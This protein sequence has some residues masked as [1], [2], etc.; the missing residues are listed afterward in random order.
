MIK[1][2]GTVGSEHGFTVV[3]LL[4]TLL[5]IT[6]VFGSFVIT[7]TTIQSINKKSLDISAANVT[8]FAKLQDYENINF[9]DLPSTVTGDLEEVEDFSDDLPQSLRSPRVGKVYINGMS[10]SLKHIVVDISFGAGA[11]QRTI[12]Y[13]SFINRNGLGR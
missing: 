10:D 2:G 5:I 8:A 1:K 12:Q 9:L 6:T 4:I 7:F 13:A 3:E 11:D